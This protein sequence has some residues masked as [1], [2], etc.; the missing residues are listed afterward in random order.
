MG[1][2]CTRLDIIYTEKG[3]LK[4]DPKVLCLLLG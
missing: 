4:D 1:R 2:F 3:A